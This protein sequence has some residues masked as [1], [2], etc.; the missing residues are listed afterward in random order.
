MKRRD[1]ITLL[2]GAAV[3]WP[4]AAVAQQPKRMPRLGIL[5]FAQQD[6]AFI[7]PCIDELET[8]GYVDGKSIAIEYRD[9]GG[10]DDRLSEQA[11]QLVGL[12]PDA[13]FSFGGEQAPIVKRATSSIPII[14]VVSN[15]P[16]ASGLVAS[17][18]RPSGNITGLTY[19]YDQLAGKMIEAVKSAVPSL[20]RVAV[21]WNPDHTDPNLEKLNVPHQLCEYS[22]SRLRC[23]RLRSSK[24][25][26]RLLHVSE[27]KPSLS[28]VRGLWRCTNGKSETSW[29][30]TDLSWLV[31][32][33]GYWE[34]E[35]F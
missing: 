4:H 33:S 2:G 12:G 11:A 15:D 35:P 7:K 24:E 14:V 10:S 18:A 30:R 17:L 21:L 6:R 22:S 23:G 27:R 9:A 20:S 5:L 13:I 16:V 28:S 8:L 29:Q 19:V 26:F 34:M 3:A 32:R 25:H 31:R 1:F